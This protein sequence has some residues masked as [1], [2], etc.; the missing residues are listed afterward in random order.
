MFT[1]GDVIVV[2]NT[3]TTDSSILAASGVTIRLA[4]TTTG[5]LT[6]AGYGVATLRMVTSNNW[7]AS[8]AGL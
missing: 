5:T 3:S 7:F 1:V 6:L 4:G 8:G 2:T